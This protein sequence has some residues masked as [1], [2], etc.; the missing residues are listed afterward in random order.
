VDI[1]D[2][3]LVRLA[4]RGDAAAFRLLV[5]RHAAVVR[6]RATRLGAHPGDVDDLV[7]E[8]FLQ[9]FAALDRLR[10]PDRF[11]PWLAG[12]LVNVHRAAAQPRPGNA[13]SRLAR[14]TPP[15]LSARAAL[16]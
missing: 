9:A 7:Q 14:I 12:I 1:G 11:G 4:R 15:S 6:A 8:A 10:D 16:S 13:A 3:D 2:G 5:E